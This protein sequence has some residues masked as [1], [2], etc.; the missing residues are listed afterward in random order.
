MTDLLK[1]KP[2]KKQIKKP[3]SQNKKAAT[4]KALEAEIKARQ[5]SDGAN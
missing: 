1:P 2:V 3:K 5:S 4:T